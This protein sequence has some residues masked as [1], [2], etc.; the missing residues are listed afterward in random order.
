MNPKYQGQKERDNALS[1]SNAAIGALD[2]VKEVSSITPAKA[3]FGTVSTLLAKIKVY[4][5]PLCS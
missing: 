1:T 2:P 4:F 3:A 5:L